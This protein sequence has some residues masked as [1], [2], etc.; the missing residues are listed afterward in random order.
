MLWVEY[1]VD[2]FGDRLQYKLGFQHLLQ[3]KLQEISFM[4]ITANST[5]KCHSES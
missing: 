5:L 2:T 3:N 1:E 4:Y